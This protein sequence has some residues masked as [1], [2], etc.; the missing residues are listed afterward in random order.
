MP[1]PGSMPRMRMPPTSEHARVNAR[2]A[3][4]TVH[5]T[6]RLAA[7][8]FERE[9]ALLGHA[10]ACRVARV[11]A[12]FHAVGAE[13]IARELGQGARGLGG[14]AAAAARGADPVADLQFGDAPVDGMQASLAHEFP[15]VAPVEAEV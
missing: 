4:R 6:A 2:V 12:D 15:I 1:R 11:A 10:P 7:H 8:A 9:S 3:Q 14:I 5:A 13:R